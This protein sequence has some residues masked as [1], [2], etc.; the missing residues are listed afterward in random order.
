MRKFCS[1]S[2]SVFW[3][4]ALMFSI[5]DAFITWTACTVWLI[6]LSRVS[7]QNRTRR[8]SHSVSFFSASCCKCN[9]MKTSLNWSADAMQLMLKHT[10]IFLKT[11]NVA[12]KLKCHIT[13]TVMSTTAVHSSLNFAT[14]VCSRQS[15]SSWTAE[16]LEK[17]WQSR[18]SMFFNLKNWWL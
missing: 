15:L 4:S 5:C 1:W 12:V 18:C 3:A 2:P 8:E 14:S 17:V 6:L 16:F 11:S 13:W 7:M 10:T 9:N